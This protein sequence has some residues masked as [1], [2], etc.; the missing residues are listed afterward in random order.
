MSINLA[1][2]HLHVSPDPRLSIEGHRV[3]NAAASLANFADETWPMDALASSQGSSRSVLTFSGLASPWDRVARWLAYH[4]INSPTPASI[5]NQANSRHVTFPSAETVRQRLGHL[6]AN[7]EWLV[8]QGVQTPAE[9]DDDHLTDMVLFLRDEGVRP[10][11]IDRRMETFRHWYAH[12][13]NLPDTLRLPVPLQANLP[14]EVRRARTSE[15]ATRRVRQA[16]MGPLMWWAS[17]F[18]DDYADIILELCRHVSVP[19]TRTDRHSSKSDAARQVLN[20]YLDTS[21]ALPVWNDTSGETAVAYLA[22]IHGVSASTL[23]VILS[24]EYGGRLPTADTSDCPILDFPASVPDE[25]VPFTQFYDAYQGGSQWP[26]LARLLQTA[27]LIVVSYLTGMRPDE[28]RRLRPGC[29]P[30]PAILPGGA[31]RH[32]IHGTVIKRQAEGDGLVSGSREEVEVVWATVPLAAR[33]VSVAERLQAEFTP[34][35]EWLFNSPFTKTMLDSSVAT[36]EIQFFLQT[37]NRRIQEGSTEVRAPS[38]PPDTHGPITL[39][40]F[41]RTLA[42]YIRNQPE[43]EAALGTQY[44][45]LGT[46]VGGGYAAAGSTGWAD[47]LDEEGRETRR[48][49]AENLGRELLDGAGISGPAAARATSAAAEL[50]GVSYLPDSELRRLLKAPGMQIYDNRAALSLCVFDPDR[51]LCERLPQPGSSATDP[52]LLGCRFGCTNRAMTDAHAN[53]VAEEAHHLRQQAQVSPIP[54]R[55]RLN[56]AADEADERVAQHWATRVIPTEI[57]DQENS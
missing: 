31:Q 30:D 41:R 57:I 13:G 45:H 49:V 32:L 19:L 15:N 42:W 29:N 37:V 2:R 52:N 46:I 54:M 23:S 17:R 9:I 43:G 12:T 26:R 3:A 11:G 8:D 55:N 36:T 40:R 27:C 10:S 1:T 20:G 44:Q 47:I 48:R 33:A 35:S 14:T 18:I 25:F 16:T 50:A 51:A 56:T 53:L 6:K 7:I 4:W 5:L 22:W 24:T 28:V 21:R 38:I 39:R 34:D